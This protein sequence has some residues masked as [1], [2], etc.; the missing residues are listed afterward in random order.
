MTFGVAGGIPPIV[1]HTDDASLS[2]YK[3]RERESRLSSDNLSRERSSTTLAT[4]EVPC[5]PVVWRGEGEAV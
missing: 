4:R 2:V 5:V 3:E 1:P